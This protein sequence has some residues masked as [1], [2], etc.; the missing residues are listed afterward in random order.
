MTIQ[1]PSWVVVILHDRL[2]NKQDMHLDL[3]YINFTELVLW[4]GM[5]QAITRT[6]DVFFEWAF[7]KL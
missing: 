5:C 4:D 7:Y 6:N 2:Y 1:H 3:S